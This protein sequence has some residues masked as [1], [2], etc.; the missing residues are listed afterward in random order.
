MTTLR[1]TDV[2]D[3]PTERLE[4]GASHVNCAWRRHKLS[5]N[6]FLGLESAFASSKHRITLLLQGVVSNP[7]ARNNIER[8]QAIFSA[9]WFADSPWAILCN[10]TH[11]TLVPRM[12]VEAMPEQHVRNDRTVEAIRSMFDSTPASARKPLSEEFFERF[13]RPRLI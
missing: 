1:W 9:A 7:N 13:I 11:A 2:I 10:S 4:F 8:G 5:K 3:R 12:S 6:K